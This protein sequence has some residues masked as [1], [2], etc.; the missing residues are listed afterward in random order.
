MSIDIKDII[1]IQCEIEDITDYI[2]VT[3]FR[4]NK[5]EVLEFQNLNLALSTLK[6]RR[7]KLIYDFDPAWHL[8]LVKRKAI[9]GGVK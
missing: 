1:A 3:V 6:A 2:A 9:S 5:K 7:N 4:D 8:E